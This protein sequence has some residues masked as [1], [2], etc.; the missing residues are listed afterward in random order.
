M[1]GKYVP[2][3]ARQ[4]MNKLYVGFSKNIELPK[5][6]F[7]F[8]DDEVPEHPKAKVFDPLLHGFNPLRS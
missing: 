5:G 1:R 7:L 8:I 6:S 4:Y 2:S 3:T